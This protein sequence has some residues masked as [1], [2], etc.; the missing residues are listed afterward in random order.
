MTRRLTSAPVRRAQIGPRTGTQRIAQR[1]THAQ[2]QKPMAVTW[3][4]FCCDVNRGSDRKTDRTDRKRQKQTNSQWVPHASCAVRSDSSSKSRPPALG[5]GMVLRSCCRSSRCTNV[6]FSSTG[7]L[8]GG[9]CPG[10]RQAGSALEGR[11]TDRRREGETFEYIRC[12]TQN[13]E[14]RNP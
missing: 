2:F 6:C 8:G 12:V 13:S 11:Q 9:P 5:E 7:V 1:H 3:A 4:C 10:D 14:A